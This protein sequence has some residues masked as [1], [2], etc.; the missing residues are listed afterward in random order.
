MCN[1][2]IYKFKYIG[3]IALLMNPLCGLAG[4]EILDI[5]VA[6]DLGYECKWGPS[7][8]PP[9]NQIIC[10]YD[11]VING[12]ESKIQCF[13]PLQNCVS[14]ITKVNYCLS[15]QINVKAVKYFFNS[16]F[17]EGSNNFNVFE[18]KDYPLGRAREVYCDEYNR[19]D[20]EQDWMI[21]TVQ[22][23]N[24]SQFNRCISDN[25]NAINSCKH[26]MDSLKQNGMIVSLMK[27]NGLKIGTATENQIIQI[28]DT[29][30]SKYTRELQQLEGNR[31]NLDTLARHRRNLNISNSFKQLVNTVNGAVR[32]LVDTIRKQM[33]SNQ[34]TIDVLIEKNL[35]DANNGVFG[36]D[37]EITLLENMRQ[38]CGKRRSIIEYNRAKVLS[39]LRESKSRDAN[40]TMD[41]LLTEISKLEK[42][43]GVSNNSDEIKNIPVY[44]DSMEYGSKLICDALNKSEVVIS[45]LDLKKSQLFDDI[46][47]LERDLVP[48]VARI[49]ENRNALKKKIDDFA[50]FRQFA[51]IH[52]L[53]K[54]HIEQKRGCRPRYFKCNFKQKTKSWHD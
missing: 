44:S 53:Y 40:K 45:E 51:K 48:D 20:Y 28:G 9:N 39:K 34:Q 2:I 38:S 12:K 29:G 7:C 15:H 50:V 37:V 18:C 33:Q 19:H 5:P 22:N 30:R 36:S 1:Q 42:G 4:I 47:D 31:G 14:D 24:P 52:E 25:T 23:T 49:I 13:M 35:N 26:Q 27:S 3:I 21:A 41:D 32:N 11:L 46:S 43:Q 6:L 8:S 16:D 54:K 17:V 10:L